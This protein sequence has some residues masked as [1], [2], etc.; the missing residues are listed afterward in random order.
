KDYV[1]HPESGEQLSTKALRQLERLRM[2]WGNKPA[3]VQIIISD[4]L[5]VRSITDEGHLPPFLKELHAALGTKDYRISETPLLIR[6]GRVRA[7]YACGE[8]LFGKSS[9]LS[10]NKGI[11]HIIGERPGTGHHNFSA[12][13]TA[14]PTLF[15]S[16]KGKVDQNISRVVSGISDT[17]LDPVKAARE[18]AGIFSDLYKTIS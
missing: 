5:N 18:V 10:Q 12:Y 14:A 15:W 3:D 8:A 6:H 11:I 17:A 2:Q 1:Y 16:Q 13:L 9:K 4:G 7:G